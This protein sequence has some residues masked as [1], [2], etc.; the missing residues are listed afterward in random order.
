MICINWMFEMW[1]H[2]ALYFSYLPRIISFDSLQ[3]HNFFSYSLALHFFKCHKLHKY[4]LPPHFRNVLAWSLCPW[5]SCLHICSFTNC[6]NILCVSSHLSLCMSSKP[7]TNYFSCSSSHAS[8]FH[9]HV[10]AFV[11]F[12]QFQLHHIPPTHF[13]SFTAL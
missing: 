2:I 9:S 11:E 8:F 4:L 1:D 10:Y 6:T 12:I 3:H 13:G 5:I 7:N